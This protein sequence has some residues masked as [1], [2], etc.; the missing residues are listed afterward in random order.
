MPVRSSSSTRRRAIARHCSALMR[1]R[2]FRDA[3]GS[4]IAPSPTAIHETRWLTFLKEF[5]VTH[6]LRAM[7]GA[8]IRAP[9]CWGSLLIGTGGQ[10]GRPRKADVFKN[11][12][13]TWFPLRRAP[14]KRRIALDSKPHLALSRL[15]GLSAAS[16][17]QVGT[18]L[19]GD[20]SAS[21]TAW[22][23]G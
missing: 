21:A 16:L 22:R 9:I 5:C 11:Q 6:T 4:S 12:I 17:L 8:D 15:T 3:Y 7:N 18:D 23:N 10:D 20:C 14:R 1:N 13:A 2:P 19:T